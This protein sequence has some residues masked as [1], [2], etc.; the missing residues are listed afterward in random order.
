MIQSESRV[1]G[2][3]A[4]TRTGSRNVATALLLGSAL[5]GAGACASGAS[6]PMDGVDPR[7]NEI[8]ILVDNQNFNQVT[9]Y[10]SRGGSFQR[11]G[12]VQGKSQHTFTTDWYYPDIPAP[13]E[14]PVGARPGHR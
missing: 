9:V 1:R 12:I 10:T 14:V 3:R 11:L 13:G 2:R 4:W 6:N 8:Q 5:L 7:S